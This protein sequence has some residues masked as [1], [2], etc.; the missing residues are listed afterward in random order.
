M[1]GVTFSWA[2]LFSSYKIRIIV[3]SHSLCF[4]WMMEERIRQVGMTEE[5][6]FLDCYVENHIL[7]I[8]TRG[9]DVTLQED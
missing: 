9:R 3:S 4:L 8:P 1:D 5:T 2:G 7:C 6:I